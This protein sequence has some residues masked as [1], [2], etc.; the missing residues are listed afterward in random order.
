VE[1]LS[2]IYKTYANEVKLFLLCLTSNI[3]LA[4]ELTQETFYRA[5]KS[6]RRYNG[7]CKPAI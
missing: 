6:I 4:E 5:V 3:D 7:A 1:D 2:D